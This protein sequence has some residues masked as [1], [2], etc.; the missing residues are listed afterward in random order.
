VR[1]LFT[2]VAALAIASAGLL[3]PVSS[4]AQASA[5]PTPPPKEQCAAKKTKWQQQQCRNYNNS[6]PGDE[7]FGRDK[8][9]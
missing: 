6:A 7:Y 4:D 3:Q 8:E 1:R 5:G 9:S 2:L